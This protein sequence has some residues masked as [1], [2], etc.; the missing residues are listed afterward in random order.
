MADEK[1]AEVQTA[2]AP[3]APVPTPLPDPLD[4]LK[5]KAETLGI[6]AT[7]EDTVDTLRAKIKAAQEPKEVPIVPDSPALVKAKAEQVLRQKIYEE[8]MYLIRCRITNMNPNKADLPGEIFTV[9]NRYVGTVRRY[10]P[11]SE[12]ENGWHLPK[13][14]FDMLKEKQFPQIKTKKGLNGQLMPETKMVNEF[15]LEILEPLTAEELKV[16]AN[17]QAAAAGLATD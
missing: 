17:R 2:K 11:Y 15:A 10:V 14:L 13:I 12:T 9:S 4:Q 6:V 1:K 8:S 7:V 16:L 5:A 3:E